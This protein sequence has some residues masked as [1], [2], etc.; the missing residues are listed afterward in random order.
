MIL[1]NCACCG[2]D[3]SIS[4]FSPHKKNNQFILKNMCEECSI[5]YKLCNG[6]LSFVLISGFK[7]KSKTNYLH[8]K[9]KKCERKRCK[10]NNPETI[11]TQIKKKQKRNKDKN[12]ALCFEYLGGKCSNP[13]C[14][15]PN[16]DWPI[17]IYDFHHRNPSE[18]PFTIAGKYH[19]NFEF[20]KKELDKC[21]LLCVLCHRLEHLKEM[22]IN[23]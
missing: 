16:K 8:S 6:C 23:D 18:K 22:M 1:K 4:E 15:L 11:R 14:Q 10:E 13:D 20:L 2:R 21:D 3:K 17:G 19:K 12:R 9:C 7:R 5:N